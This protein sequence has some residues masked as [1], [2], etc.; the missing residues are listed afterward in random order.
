MLALLEGLLERE[1][2]VLE[3]AVEIDADDADEEDEDD[4]EDEAADREAVEDR[5]ARQPTARS[6][7][8]P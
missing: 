7:P 3:G 5:V 8:A 2:E 1:E 4:E 6:A